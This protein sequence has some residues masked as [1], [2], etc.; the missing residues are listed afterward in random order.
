MKGFR[1]GI[2]GKIAAVILICMIP[3]LILG[4]MLF[5]YRNQGRR[6][7]VQRG[8]REAARA[9]AS[10]VQG[11]LAGAVAAERT[12]GAA[13]TSQ[14]YPVSGILQLF[15]AIQASDRSFLSLMLIDRSGHTV[16][17]AP[18]ASAAELAGDP[19]VVAVRNGNPWAAGPPVWIDQRPTLVVAT[20]IWDASRLNAIVAGRL[21]LGLLR[22]VLP[23]Q[24]PGMWPVH[25]CAFWRKRTG[26]LI[27]DAS[28]VSGWVNW[29]EYWMNAW[30][31]PIDIC[32]DATRRPPISAMAT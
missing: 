6:D 27:I 16:A 25:S 1:L 4:V 14:P 23:R 20:A 8:H 30:M 24:H 9:I 28:C 10:S 15:A 5:Q 11:F 29:R 21:D 32:P 31:S 2:R 7:V 12:V 17:A 3:V 26:T 18:G 19:A 13:V 22:A